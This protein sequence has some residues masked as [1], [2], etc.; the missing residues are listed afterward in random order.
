MLGVFIINSTK[1]TTTIEQFN[2]RCLKC[3]FSP[4]KANARVKQ[5]TSGLKTCT[6]LLGTALTTLIRPHYKTDPVPFFLI[7]F[8]EVVFKQKARLSF[9]LETE[10][11]QKRI[12]A[13]AAEQKEGEDMSP[14]PQCEETDL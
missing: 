11:G 10:E 5:C 1:S 13:T 4:T 12:S 8:L 7:Y 9:N 6:R 14:K 2:A 3:S